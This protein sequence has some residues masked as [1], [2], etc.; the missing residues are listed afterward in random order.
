MADMRIKEWRRLLRR[1]R[2]HG[3]VETGQYMADLIRTTKYPLYFIMR[4]SEYMMAKG[5]YDAAGL[6]LEAAVAGGVSDPVIDKLYAKWLWC[7]GKRGAAIQYAQEKAKFWQRSYLYLM[8]SA[9]HSLLG[10]RAKAE[11]YSRLAVA[12]GDTEEAQRFFRHGAL[13]GE[14]WLAGR[15]LQDVGMG[16]QVGP[17]RPKGRH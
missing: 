14:K 10:D 2:R 16:D 3:P 1:V 13:M 5:R 6:A 12:L 15:A 9:F 8:V 17:R 11:S 7:I 4:F